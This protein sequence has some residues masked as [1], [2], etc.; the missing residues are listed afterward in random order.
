MNL[1]SKAEAGRWAAALPASRLAELPGAAHLAFLETP[2]AAAAA[3][4]A[5][6]GGHVLSTTEGRAKVEAGA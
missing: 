3:L 4:D 6:L 1:D 5:H 2:E